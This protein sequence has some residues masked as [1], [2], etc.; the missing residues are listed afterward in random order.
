MDDH[1]ITFTFDEPRMDFDFANA[2]R[3]SM[4]IYSKAQFDAEGMEGYD[5]DPAG[6]GHFRFVEREP[7][8]VLMETVEDHWSGTTPDFEELEL[9][10]T[11][12]AATKLAMLLAGEADIAVIPRELQGDATDAGHGD[13]PVPPALEAGRHHAGRALHEGGRPGLRPRAALDRRQGCARR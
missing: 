4:Y 12:E 13:R 1:T 11:A 6:T 8:R 3:G 5:A 7:G 9:R 2:G 10:F